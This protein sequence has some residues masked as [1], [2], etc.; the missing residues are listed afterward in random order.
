[1]IPAPHPRSIA[2]SGSTILSTACAT[3][4]YTESKGPTVNQLVMLLFV[5]FSLAPYRTMEKKNGH[6]GMIGSLN[7][8]SANFLSSKSISGRIDLCL[9]VLRRSLMVTRHCLIGNHFLIRSGQ[10]VFKR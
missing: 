6:L 5:V 1:M 7:M 3:F 2:A 8:I 4:A 10:K 9:K